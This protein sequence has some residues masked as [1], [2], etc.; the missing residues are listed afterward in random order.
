MKL[1]AHVARD[2]SIEGMIAGGEQRVA[3]GIVPGPGIEVC[4]IEGHGLEELD[5][6]GL[7]SLLDTRTVA[8]TPARGKLLPRKEQGS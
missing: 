1:Y 4:E 7:E 8:R 5:C 3:A 6:D 2:G